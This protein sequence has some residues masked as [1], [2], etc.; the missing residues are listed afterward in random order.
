MAADEKGCTA[1]FGIVGLTRAAALD[2]ASSNIRINALCPGI[3]STPM[4]DRFSGGTPEGGERVIA[5][6]G[7][8]D[9]KAPRRLPQPSSGC[10]RTGPPSS[11][12]TRWSLMAA[13]PSR[14]LSAC[15]GGPSESMV[16]GARNHIRSH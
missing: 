7:R 3:I 14:A 2:Y 13:K 15:A 6:T 8:P 11:S 5:R 1:K 4:M 12:D 16:A 9:G 10:A